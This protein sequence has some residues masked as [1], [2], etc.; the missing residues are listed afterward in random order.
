[1]NNIHIENSYKIWKQD[2]MWY[3]IN[4]F[5]KQH[6]IHEPRFY[7]NRT[8]ESM[9]FEWRMHNIGYYVTLPLIKFKKFKEINERCK[10]VDLEEYENEYM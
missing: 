1:M 8:Y 10:H 9:F 6:N 2:D 7:L 3:A 5:C 4:D